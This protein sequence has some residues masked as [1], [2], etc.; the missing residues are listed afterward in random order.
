M[1]AILDMRKY[2]PHCPRPSTNSPIHPRADSTPHPRYRPHTL[3]SSP[4]SELT[5]YSLPP[6]FKVRGDVFLSSVGSLRFSSTSH[7]FS[8]PGENLDGKQTFLHFVLLFIITRVRII[9]FFFFVHATKL[10]L[11]RMRMRI[12]VEIRIIISSINFA[13]SLFV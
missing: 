8:T 10:K 9:F 1:A 11:I 13:T 2:P 3:A 5:P 6:S 4:P 12:F 7:F